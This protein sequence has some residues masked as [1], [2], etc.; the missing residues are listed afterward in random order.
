M[1]RV[2]YEKQ[3]EFYDRGRSLPPEAIAVWMAIA[4]RYAGDAKRILDLGSGTGRFT[5]A[6]AETFDA[7]VVAVEPSRGMQAQ[8][9]TKQTPPRVNQLTAFAEALSLADASI[10]LAWLSNVIH[11][12]DD[13][14]RATHELRRVVE[15]GGTV[16]VRGAFG[17]VD[18][19]TLYRFFPGTQAFVDDS[20]PTVPEI[21]AAFEGAGFTSFYHERVEQLVANSLAEMV[22][23]LRL[24]ADT[25]LEH[26][27]DEEFEA[28]LRAIEQAAKTET[29]PLFDLLDV[30][31]IR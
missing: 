13:L 27:S 21:F 31:V 22:P 15:A 23:R 16:L 2:D 10:D 17:R 25:T 9:A 28:G 20:F 7:F 29:G 8:A 11:H 14:P 1:A 5:A 4:R 26:L 12:F 3:S 6:L 30:L 18:D 19:S 24:R